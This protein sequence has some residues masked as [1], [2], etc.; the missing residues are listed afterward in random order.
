MHSRHQTSQPAGRPLQIPAVLDVIDGVIGTGRCADLLTGMFTAFTWLG[1][2]YYG[3]ELRGIA[4]QLDISTGRLALLQVAYE[5]FA[6]CTSIVA[7]SPAASGPQHIRTMD[8]DLPAL[9]CMTIEV[10]FCRGGTPLFVATTW[11]GYVGVLTG[12]RFSGYSVSV[13][14]RRTERGH[15]SPLWAVLGNFAR[16][17]TGA[18]PISFLVRAVLTDTPSYAQA[19]L[20]LQSSDL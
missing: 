7:D 18:W 15:Q 4:R 14:Y 19:V 11:P 9:Q 12:M 8:W 3:D 17:L 10:E 20:Q 16:G 6:M 1:G 2:I 13:N 5:V